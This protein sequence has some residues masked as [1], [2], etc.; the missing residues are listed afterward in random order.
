MRGLPRQLQHLRHRCRMAHGRYSCHLSSVISPGIFAPRLRVS[1]MDMLTESESVRYSRQLALPQVGREGQE[2]LKCASVLVIGAGGLGSLSALYLAGAGVGR[3][4]VVDFDRVDVTNLHRQL[5]HGTA[6]VG[7]DKVD[8]A[9]GRLRDLNP[10]VTLEAH[11]ASLN[12]TNAFE[13]L[14]SYDVVVDGSD[15]FPT[16]YLVNDAC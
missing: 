1:A 9:L 10:E 5:L 14:G 11:R 6:D 8:S 2:K 16:R 4:G 15:N 13:I 3:I 7:R 12:S